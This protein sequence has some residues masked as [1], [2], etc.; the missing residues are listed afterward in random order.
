MAK[1]FPS[2]Q[3]EVNALVKLLNL[4]TIILILAVG[5]Y[6]L[7]KKFNTLPLFILLGIALGMAYSFYEAWQIHK[8][9]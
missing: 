1:K 8:E 4:G 3:P 5:G 9:E 7:D 6:W 2:K